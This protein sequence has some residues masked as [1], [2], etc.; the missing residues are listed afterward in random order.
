MLLHP[1]L[2]VVTRSIYGADLHGR[3]TS[4]LDNILKCFPFLSEYCYGLTYFR[5]NYGEKERKEVRFYLHKTCTTR[6]VVKHLAPKEKLLPVH[7]FYWHK[8]LGHLPLQFLL[9]LAHGV[10]YR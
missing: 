5:P 4:V 9:P 3:Q 7:Q 1:Y 6:L 10:L 8:E 2:A